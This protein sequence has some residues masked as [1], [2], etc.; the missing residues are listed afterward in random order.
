M[1]T[2]QYLDIFIDESTE[3]LDT[4]Y[5]QLLE[6]EKNPDEKK[7]IEEIFRA[8]HTLKGMSATM[9]YDDLASLTHKLENIFDGIRYDKITVQTEMM[10]Y[11]FT[12]V[13]YL[14][15]MVEDIANGGDGKKDV[16]EIVDQ[17]DKIEK[18]EVIVDSNTVT[19]E[20]ANNRNE[21]SSDVQLDEFQLTIL[22]ESKDRGFDNFEI[23]VEL[24]EDCLLK[25]ARVY[26][27]FE[28]LE[29]FGEVIY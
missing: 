24:R 2:T 27:V 12:A 23:T 16:Q 7:I 17:L 6:L 21:L 28:L 13:D 20:P 1:E 3:H 18:G 14:N 4:L 9:G 19:K 10:D 15:A 26:M 29:K 22:S 5:Q 11:L 8:A 25:G